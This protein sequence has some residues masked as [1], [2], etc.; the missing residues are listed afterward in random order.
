VSSL[1]LGHSSKLDGNSAAAS[2]LVPLFSTDATSE[3]N[4]NAV[5]KLPSGEEEGEANKRQ[6]HAGRYK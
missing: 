5:C 6:F 4:A 3:R 1:R 2:V